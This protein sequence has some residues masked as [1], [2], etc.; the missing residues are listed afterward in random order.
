V[1]LYRRWVVAMSAICMK[2]SK[3][4]R[5][6]FIFRLFDED[7]SGEIDRDEFAELVSGMM[8]TQSVSDEE[9]KLALQEEFDAA[10]TDNSGELNEKEFIAAA[11]NS[12]R[13]SSYFDRLSKISESESDK[14]E[15]HKLRRE[16]AEA[17]RVLQARYRGW[18]TRK[19]MKDP[20]WVP[21]GR[22]KARAFTK[23]IVFSHPCVCNLVTRF[24]LASF[25]CCCAESRLKHACAFRL[26]YTDRIFNEVVELSMPISEG[27]EEGLKKLFALADLEHQM[28]LG[29][30]QF[31]GLLDMLE[32]EVQKDDAMRMFRAMDEDGGGF[33]EFVEFAEAML[34]QFSENEIRDASS[35]EIGNMGTRMWSRGEI[36]W[37]IN[38]CLIISATCNI[39][40]GMIYFKFLLVPLFISY[41]LTFLMAP[42]M[43]LFEARPC[44][45]QGQRFCRVS[46]TK[47]RIRVHGTAQAELYDLVHSCKFPHGVSV[48]ATLIVCIATLATIG[49]VAGSEFLDL[50]G[51]ETFQKGWD[52]L[53]LDTREFLNN[54]GI[55]LEDDDPNEQGYYNADLVN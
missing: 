47:T 12:E 49:F 20:D 30:S 36:G 37:S 19:K 24:V 45:I 32:M 5:V 40:Y 46:T 38:S 23:H 25:D 55:E 52:D 41:F 21:P 10:D 13:L 44:V 31:R 9:M 27:R 8:L 7:G 42:L 50:M 51:D 16:Q 39:I 1:V 34:E 28:K 29:P 14:A 3:E 17:A 6:S 53:V 22:K 26:S 54:S 48:V 2:G 4:K 33:I 43:T 35:M 11:S 15:A 18:S